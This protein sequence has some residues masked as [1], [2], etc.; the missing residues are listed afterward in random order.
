MLHSLLLS[1]YILHKNLE[2]VILFDRPPSNLLRQEVSGTCIYLDVLQKSTGGNNSKT[3]RELGLSLSEK[4]DAS[5]KNIDEELVGIAEAKLV[6]FCAQVIREASEF[7]SS[8]GETTNMDIHRVL[9][10]RSP[11]IVKVKISSLLVCGMFYS[12]QVLLI[13]AHIYLS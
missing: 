8:M 13:L 12:D 3:E 11:V 5:Q 4:V 6:S 2:H 7:Q 1:S 10:L 9:E